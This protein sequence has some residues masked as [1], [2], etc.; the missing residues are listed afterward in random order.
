VARFVA[1]AAK[2]LG[3]PV[4]TRPP[5]AGGVPA[6]LESDPIAQLRRAGDRH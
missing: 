1:H 2:K 5:Q 6:R 3:K 4:A